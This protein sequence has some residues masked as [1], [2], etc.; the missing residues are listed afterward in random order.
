MTPYERIYAVVRRIPRGRV[1]SY[2]QVAKLAGLDGR[3]RQVGY[4]LHAL[5]SDG[6]PWHRVINAAG[7]I[8]LKGPSAITQR[9]R[10]EGEGIRCDA[11]GRIDLARFG[12]K[13]R[14]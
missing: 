10:L 3:A 14:R 2:G 9:I 1:A 12:W 5:K 11:G 13:K 8:S 6:V 7:K 4:A